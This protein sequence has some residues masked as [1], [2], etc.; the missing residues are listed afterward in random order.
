MTRLV[1]QVIE[2]D[3]GHVDDDRSSTVPR[4]VTSCRSIDICKCS[5]S[6]RLKYQKPTIQRELHGR[7]GGCSPEVFGRSHF[8]D[9]PARAERR[10]PAAFGVCSSVRSMGPGVRCG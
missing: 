5:H 4:N 3:L 7:F 8:G 6:V 10:P 2:R 1:E 9:A